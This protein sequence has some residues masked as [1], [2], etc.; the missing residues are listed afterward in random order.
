MPPVF[1]R[2][3]MNM[4]E[5]LGS[6]SIKGTLSRL[7]RILQENNKG[8]IDYQQKWQSDLGKERPESQWLI[9]WS[10]P[11]SSKIFNIGMQFFK[12]LCHWYYTLARL[13][14]FILPLV[15]CVGKIVDTEG[16]FGTVG[17]NVRESE[18]FGIRSKHILRRLLL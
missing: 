16:V 12:F 13:V 18:V 2:K 14:M 4:E 10:S 8:L 5:L 11:N 3:L 15:V 1:N 7:Y 17:R 9:I 6:D